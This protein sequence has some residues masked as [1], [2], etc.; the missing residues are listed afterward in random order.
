MELQRHPPR[1]QPRPRRRPGDGTR[2]ARVDHRGHRPHQRTR[3][4]APRRCAVVHGRQH[5]P[6]RRW[7]DIIE[8]RGGD[9]IIDGDRWLNA[10]LKVGNTK[11]PGLTT[12]LRSAVAAGT[13]NP[14]SISIFRSIVTPAP[15]ATVDVAVFSDVRNS[16]VVTENANGS[17]TVNHS[18]GT[19]TDGIDTL[20]NIERLRFADGSVEFGRDQHRGHRHGRHQRQHADGGP[21]T[22][23]QPGAIVDPDGLGAITVTWQAEIEEGTWAQVHVGPTFTPSDNRWVRRCVSLPTSSTAPA[24]PSR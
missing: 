16:Y 17:I 2:R 10:E 24:F 11:Y 23:R 3:C 14:G 18:G 13:I 19:A 9:D 5:H 4:P 1:R 22:H 12:G 15:S 7:S 8:G 20:W 6:R 21:D